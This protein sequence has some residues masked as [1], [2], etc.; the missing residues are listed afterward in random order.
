MD[1]NVN[2]FTDFDELLNLDGADW[3]IQPPYN[4]LLCT[5]LS[6]HSS[7]MTSY[8][9]QITDAVHG[10]SL[11]LADFHNCNVQSTP[12]VQLSSDL[13][14]DLSTAPVYTKPPVPC[15]YCAARG[16]ECFFIN[17]DETGCSCC[18]ALF[19][20]CSFVSHRPKS[21]W[22]DTLDPVSEDIATDIGKV[23]GTKP[24]FR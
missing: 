14:Y 12:D 11:K 7:E 19:R 3:G 8:S 24:L 16:L 22:L 4:D 10:N 20:N 17:H 9:P 15:D 6:P 5:D 13:S 1:F 23:T 2:D 21:G 18:R